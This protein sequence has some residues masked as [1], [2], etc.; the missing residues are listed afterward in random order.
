MS[1]IAFPQDTI[2]ALSS[3]RLPS[4]VAVVRVSGPRVRFVLETIIGILPTPRNAA[5]KLFRARNGDPIDHGLVLFFPGPNSFTG[6]DCAEFH[7]HGGKAV[8]ERLLAELGEIAGCRIAEAGEF[9]RRAFSNGKMDLTI[10]EGLADLIAAETEGQRRLALQVASGT[11]RELYTE[12]RQRLLRAR[13][14]IEAELDFADESDV[15]GSVSEQ[16]WQS[17]ALLRTEIENHIASG[18]RASMLRDG[19][20]VVIVGAPNAGKSSLLNFLAGREVAIISE[21]AGTTRDLLEVKL[22]LGGIPVYVTDT[23]GLRET[24][25]VVEKIG[26]ERARARMADADLV[27]L[28]ED[29]NDPVVIGTEET[30]A[31]LWTVGTKADLSEK[32]DGGWSYRISTR[33]GEGL[34]GLLTDLQNFAEAQIGQIEDAVPTRQR[35]ISLLRSTVGEIDKALNGTNFPLELRAENMR[36]ASQYLGRITGDVDVEEI[37]DVIFSQFCIGK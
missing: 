17:L 33:T 25:S 1:E 24:E 6:E 36:L 35:H 4:G 2:F 34:D 18:K 7:A 27:L 37:L 23:A 8:V 3:G 9:T 28:L 19:L 11:Q 13:A 29:M 10:A 5:Y 16:V 32:A 26:I 31:T 22:D 15:P 30:P 20:H 14:F 21:E 12:W